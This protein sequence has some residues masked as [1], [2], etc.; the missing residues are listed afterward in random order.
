[1]QIC[2]SIYAVS[3]LTH[4]IVNEKPVDKH[5]LPED[6]S[7]PGTCTVCS[8]CM[9]ARLL[10]PCLCVPINRWLLDFS[11]HSFPGK[12]MIIFGRSFSS[13][14]KSHVSSWRGDQNT[15]EVNAILKQCQNTYWC[16]YKKEIAGK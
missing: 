10:R 11:I 14:I 5:R 1:M 12:P 4:P 3:T 13:L 9:R 16:Q 15:V 8:R 6:H 7:P 2:A